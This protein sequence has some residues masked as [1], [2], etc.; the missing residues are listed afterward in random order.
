MKNNNKFLYIMSSMLAMFI[1]CEDSDTDPAASGTSI[2]TPATYVFES[3]F[4]P[5]ESSV[6]YN[7]SK[8]LR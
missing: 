4:N 6:Y 1:G 2:E 3:R 7:H 8:T 5:G